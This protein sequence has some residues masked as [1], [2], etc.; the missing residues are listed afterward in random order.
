MLPAKI[1]A[2]L[3]EKCCKKYAIRFICSDS[4]KIIFAL[5][6]KVI[7]GPVVITHINVK[8]A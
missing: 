7:V 8:K 2:I 5:L 6:I 1:D 3:K 4:G